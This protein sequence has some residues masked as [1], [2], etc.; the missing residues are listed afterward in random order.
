VELDA[1]GAVLTLAGRDERRLGEVPVAAQRITGD[2][3]DP[4]VCAMAVSVA[5][6]S[7][8]LDILINAVGSVAFGPVWEVAPEVV[9]EL[10]E[11][12]ALVPIL[13]ASAALPRMRQGGAIVNISGV[14]A[15]RPLPNMTAYS[16]A[17]GAVRAFDM[18]LAR[19]ARRRGVRV[20]DARP[21]H[22]ETGLARRPLAGEAPALAK[23][24]APERVAQV[25]VRALE[26][27]LDDLP[28]AAFHEPPQAPQAA[29]VGVA[30]RTT[31]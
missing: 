15:E 10:L 25:I 19:E 2:L 21:P 23:G 8:G 5:A 16:A 31:P 17:K 27:G 24:L 1:R 22:T 7:E 26:T 20:I 11:V 28:S 3:R 14:I 29:P 13:L 6:A 9:R 4:A 18:A 12:N 30:P